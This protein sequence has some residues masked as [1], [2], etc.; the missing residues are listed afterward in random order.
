M[1]GSS[2]SQDPLFIHDTTESQHAKVNNAL[3]LMESPDDSER[4]SVTSV[5][6]SVDT[7]PSHMPEPRVPDI[8]SSSLTHNAVE[9]NHVHNEATEKGGGCDSKPGLVNSVGDGDSATI[10]NSTA[11]GHH[12]CHSR[13]ASQVS[14]C[15]ASVGRMSGRDLCHSRG[16]ST[17]GS[18]MDAYVSSATD[19]RRGTYSEAGTLPIGSTIIEENSQ[20]WDRESG[21]KKL[22]DSEDSRTKYSHKL[23]SSCNCCKNFLRSHHKLPE[24]P[25]VG[26]LVKYSFTCPPHGRVG[27]CL[28]WL[29]AGLALWGCL[30]SI[31]G[32]MA[33]PGGNFFSLLV[34]YVMAMLAGKAASF[35]GLPPL[36]G[37]LVVGILFSSIPGINAVG[38]N[39]DAYWSS[40]LRNI[41]LIIILIRAGLGLDPVALKKLSCTVLRLAFLPCSIEAVCTGVVSKFF[42]G[43]PWSWSFM[44][45]F[46]V[47]AV[48]PAVV[49]PCLLKLG[50]EGYGVDKGIPTLVIAAASI[51]DVIAITG[52]SV[53]L[54]ITFAEGSL[55][56]TILKGPV[57]ILAGIMYGIGFGLLCWFL[58]YKEKERR[59]TYK[60][61]IIFGLG[62]LG[63]FG[64]HKVGLESS[65]PIAVLT[66]A[67]V[68]GLGWR[69]PGNEDADVSV[70]YRTLWEIFQPMLFVLIGAE[71]DVAVI[72]PGTVGWGLLT[73][74]IC[75]SLRVATSFVV[76]MGTA[77]TVWERLFIAIAW[78]PKATVQAA[79]GSQAL[80]YVRQHD[81]E[82]VDLIRGQQIVTIAVMVIL[83]TAPLGAAA[84]K[85]TGPRFLAKKLPNRNLPDDPET[86][87]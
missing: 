73:L 61:I 80:D 82:K 40:S 10:S 86:T 64:S 58:P 31:T 16:A 20:G 45:G 75:L 50:E 55:F 63:M 21:E 68:A 27:D 15:E 60:F 56:W 12:M 67:F 22:S 3:Q 11:G 8:P 18:L 4:S 42:L 49:V 28:I 32:D 13:G 74:A 35:V 5:A 69:K 44:L 72:D 70:Y 33:L 76:V 47:A 65:G 48:S 25:T 77:F 57:E 23:I 7:P 24:H 17:D 66:L 1:E 46:I 71:I 36:L 9:E 43:L 30:I 26:E 38:H 79:I 19:S 87:V 14:S 62:A 52:F 59:A 83:V 85:L 29:V 81:G 34:L 84:I 51:D 41:A 78:L 53:M 2:D 37:S 39:I 54:G 6:A